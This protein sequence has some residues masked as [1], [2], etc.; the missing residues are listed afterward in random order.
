MFYSDILQTFLQFFINGLLVGAIYSLIGVGAV[1]IVK[2]T[3]VFNF[4]VG[5]MLMLGGY[6]AYTLFDTGIPPIM[7]VILS[8]SAGVLLGLAI[9]RIAL[10]PMI[11]QP[12]MSSIMVTLALSFL[13]R[14]VTLLVWGGYPRVFPKFLP[15]HNFRAGGVLWSY[16]LLWIFGGTMLLFGLFCIF[17]KFTRFGLDMRATS[18]D[19]TL[20]Q[21]RGIS[22]KRIFALT[23]AIAGVTAVVGGVFLGIK[24]TLSLGLADVGLKAFSAVIFG[25]FESIG[26]VL[27]GGLIVGILEN[28]AG[29]FLDPSLKEIVP[30][31]ILLLVLIFRPEGLFG[32]KRIERI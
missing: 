31:I 24:L 29:G 21:T 10:R 11:G 22:V 27:I 9:E 8:V 12:T 30:Y 13:L 4:A 6:I 25:G 1:V 2:S 7:V 20:A 32:L 15:G 26:G 19:H 3:K 5:D 14:G 16:E 17:Y 18:E 23:W 28:L